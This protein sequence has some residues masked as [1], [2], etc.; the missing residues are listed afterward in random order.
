MTRRCCTGLAIRVAAFYFTLAGV[1]QGIQAEP[2]V[3]FR[4]VHDTLIVISLTAND[5]GPFE[6]V[7]DTGADTTIV[8]PSLASSLSLVPAGLQQQSTLAGVRELACSLI[9]SMAMG[10]GTTENVKVLVE[11]LSELRKMDPRIAGIA[12]Q[13]FLSHFNYL[14]DYPKHWLRIEQTDEIERAFYGDR[15]SMERGQNRMIVRAEAQSVGR[16]TLRL[17][18]DSGASTL[19]LLP[20][21]C[22]ALD[23]SVQGDAVETTSSGNVGLRVGRIHKLIV[24]SQQLHEI[25]VVLAATAPAESIGDGLLP[26]VLFQSLYVNN[27]EGFVV[28][29]PRPKKN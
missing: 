1:G 19:A 15:V 10:P 16:A 23:L 24:G 28:L 11:D 3:R 9:A 22:A 25:R 12:G 4:L 29:N 26:T 5:Q 20:A 21:S 17:L 7:L 27:R 13:N 14:L 8:D 18:L 2:G 6:F